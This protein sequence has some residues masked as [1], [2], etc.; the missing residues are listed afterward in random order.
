[1]ADSPR[2][3]A[4]LSRHF[5]RIFF[6]TVIPIGRPDKGTS[7]EFSGLGRGDE[8]VLRPKPIRPLQKLPQS[9]NLLIRARDLRAHGRIRPRG[10][11]RR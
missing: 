1:M 5:I 11:G 2:S 10:D 7:N 9:L 8:P 6:Q 4:I 3:I